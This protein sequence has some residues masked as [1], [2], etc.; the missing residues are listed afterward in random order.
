MSHEKAIRHKVYRVALVFGGF[1]RCFLWNGCVADRR[2]NRE[3]SQKRIIIILTRPGFK[4]ERQ[5]VRVIYEFKR[6]QRHGVHLVGCS[7][8][9]FF[10]GHIGVGVGIQQARVVRFVVFVKIIVNHV[11]PAGN[12]VSA[13]ESVGNR[14]H[15]A[16]AVAQGFLQLLHGIDRVAFFHKV[17]GRANLVIGVVFEIAARALFGKS[18]H[19]EGVFLAHAA[20]AVKKPRHGVQKDTAIVVEVVD[21]GFKHIVLVLKAC[22]LRPACVGEDVCRGRRPALIEI[23]VLNAC[24]LGVDKVKGFQL[25]G[26]AF[27]A[28][29][30]QAVLHR[31]YI[32]RRK[33]R[34]KGA[35]VACQIVDVHRVVA[36]ELG[37][38]SSHRVGGL[39][40]VESD[41]QHGLALIA[42]LV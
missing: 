22:S 17:I 28:G 4:L 11:A 8:A 6:L 24:F 18:R 16:A 23:L 26:L 35:L 33:P 32:G 3:I 41:L 14:H 13:K 12:G 30:D 34:D 7:A 40:V 42:Q 19:A 37:G 38:G 5:T 39:N 25:K 27:G 20:Y 1:K 9:V 10:V 21:K 36:V 29:A 15:H 2:Q 31:L